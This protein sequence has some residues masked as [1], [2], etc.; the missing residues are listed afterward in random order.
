MNYMCG[1]KRLTRR[2]TGERRSTQS[3]STEPRPRHVGPG[4][5]KSFSAVD[6]LQGT[7]RPRR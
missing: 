7:A 1:S 3:A 4:S 6:L 5:L 2:Y